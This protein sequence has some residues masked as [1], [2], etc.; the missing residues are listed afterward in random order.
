M[1]RA[2]ACAAAVALALAVL[3]LRGGGPAPA[4][5]GSVL[6]VG[7]SLVVGTTPYL[8][9]ELSGVTVTSDGRVGRPSPEAVGV[10]RA[11]LGG[12][13]VVVFDAGVND[14]P[15]QPSRLASDLATV[16]GLVGGRCL[17]VATMIRPPYNGVTVDGLNRAVRS[18]AAATPTARLVDWR[19]AGL[20]NRRLVNPDGVHPTAAGYALRA[21]LFA[22]AIESCSSGAPPASG[23]SPAPGTD[24]GAVPPPP[25]RPGRGGRKAP[26]RT[27]AR[28]APRRPPPRLGSQSS[29]V[30]DEP[31]SVASRG[32]RLSGELLAPGGSG[33]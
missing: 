24:T 25:P 28:P 1:S 29:V 27:P 3:L 10:L 33:R 19:A 8:R 5:T 16:R 21:Q 12:Q 2:P 23:G 6:V 30:L 22:R 15:A 11:K 31:I 14:D 7:D 13:R 9:R 4:A 32:A 18:F 20:A 26:P 17:V